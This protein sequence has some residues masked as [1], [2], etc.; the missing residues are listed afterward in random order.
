MDAVFVTLRGKAGGFGIA[1][2]VVEAEFTG[3]VLGIDGKLGA[4]RRGDCTLGGTLGGLAWAGPFGGF[5]GE[6]CAPSCWS[7]TRGFCESPS[8]LPDISPSGE[9]GL[10]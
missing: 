2:G 9:I 10:G 4:C 8:V 6:A 1:A 7:K 5:V 3:G